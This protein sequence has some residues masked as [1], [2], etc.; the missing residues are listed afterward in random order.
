MTTPG[1]VLELDDIAESAL[2][3]DETYAAVTGRAH[4]RANGRGV[5][6]AAVRADGVQHRDGAARD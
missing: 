6:D 3:A 1:A 5:V 4:R 2:L